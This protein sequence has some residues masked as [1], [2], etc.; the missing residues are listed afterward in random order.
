[1]IRSVVFLF[2][3]C[4]FFYFSS[5]KADWILTEWRFCCLDMYYRKKIFFKESIR[6]PSSVMTFVVIDWILHVFKQG[7]AIVNATLENDTQWP[8]YLSMSPIITPILAVF[9]THITHLTLKVTSCQLFYNY[10]MHKSHSV[11]SAWPRGEAHVPQVHK[12][13]SF[14]TETW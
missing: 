3:V 11:T 4:L 1:M 14:V 5:R 9:Q 6:I 7:K 10:Q 8:M 12:W 2:F 13:K